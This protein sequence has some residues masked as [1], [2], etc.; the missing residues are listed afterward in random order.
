[1]LLSFAEIAG[2]EQSDKVTPSKFKSWEPHDYAGL[3]QRHLGARRATPTRLLEIGLGCLMPQGAGRSIPIWRR[4]LPCASVSILDYA[5][6]C[7]EPFRPQLEG[8]FLGDQSNAAVLDAAVLAGA[9]YDVII[10]DGSHNSV[11]QIKSFAHL[12]PHVAGRRLHHRR[13]ALRV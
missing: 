10:D 5:A 9:P 7:A 6:E 11:H 2:S 13:P 12:F 8:L 3:Y 1:M 4:F